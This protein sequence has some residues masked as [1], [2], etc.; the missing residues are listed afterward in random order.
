MKRRTHI[1]LGMLSTGVILLFL[2]ALGIRPEMPV[3]DLIILGGIF[4]ILPDIDLLIRKHRN[5]LTHSIL[6]S[7]TIFLMIIL[8]SIIKLGSTISNFFTWDSAIV[9]AAAV[10]SH[11]LADSITSSGVPLYYPFSKRQHVH[12]PVIGGRVRYD[13]FFANSAIELSAIFILIIL[14]T[15]SIFM[16]LE[17]APE[18]FIYLIKTVLGNF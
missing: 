16:G 8:L 10:L 2:I 4:G 9:A 12:F 1:A 11:T 18:N 6:T 14:F 7:I 13:N 17:T 5:G 15:S 3:G